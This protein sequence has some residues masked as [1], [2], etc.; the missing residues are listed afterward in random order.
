MTRFRPV[1]ELAPVMKYPAIPP[2]SLTPTMLQELEEGGSDIL[3]A[4]LIVNNGDKNRY[5]ELNTDFSNAFTFG[6]NQYCLTT[7]YVTHILDK[8]KPMVL[9][10]PKKKNNNKNK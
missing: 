6:K 8:F 10:V 1:A 7:E 9:I 4:K 5:G 2:H 3:Y